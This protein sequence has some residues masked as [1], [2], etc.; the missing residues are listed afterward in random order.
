[1]K[2][3]IKTD[4][5]DSALALLSAHENSTYYHL[6]ELVNFNLTLKLEFTDLA[7]ISFKKLSSVKT[8][9]DYKNRLLGHLTTIIAE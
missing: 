7:I 3:L 9:A 2:Y 6:E 4:Q 1:M 5:F 8:D